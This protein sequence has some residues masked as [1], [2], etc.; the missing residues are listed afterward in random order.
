MKQLFFSLILSF[1]FVMGNAQSSLQE[2]IKA[3]EN[4]NYNLAENIFNS[5]C[6]ADP[7]NSVAH[8]WLGEVSYAKEEY[9]EAEKRYKKGLETNP[10][11]AECHIGLGKLDLD[12]GKVPEAE[13][14][15]ESA[16]RINKKS[17]SIKGLIGDAYLYTKKPNANKAIEYL[18]LASDG[19]PKVGKYW[20]HLGD[21]YNLAGNNGEAMTNYER[22]VEKDPTNTE[23]YIRMA[24]IWRAAKQINDAIPH[25]EKAMQLAP[26]DARPIKDLY[27]LYIYAGKY[28]KVVPLLEKYIALSGTDVEARVRLVKFLAFQAKDYERAITE[29][30]KLLLTSPDQYTLYRWLAWSYVGQAKMMEAQKTAGDS[31]DEAKLKVYWKNAYDHSVK[32]FDDI[33]KKQE[34]KSYPEDYDH[35]ALSA[36]KTGSLEKAAHIYRKYI[37]LE[38]ARANEIYGTLARTY[39]DSAQHE[40]AIK[41]YKLKAIEK[42]L[43]TSEEYY[44]ALAH[45]HLKQ[46][47]ESDSAFARILV[48][49]PNYVQGHLYRAKI[50]NRIDSTNTLFLALPHYEKVIEF[51]T[52][53]EATQEKNKRQLLEAYQW[54]GVY[55]V[56]Q[57][58]NVKGK[59][60]FLKMLALDPGNAKAQEYIEILER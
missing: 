57:G 26:D 28:D 31:I 33:A 43:T 5:L 36:L 32:L 18:T 34:R 14:H 45:Y 11:C 9:T 13:S 30:E 55:Y 27:E 3:L 41:Y 10:Q 7:K 19:D 51:A 58:D 52:V 46:N 59:E 1:L 40:Q 20:A 24:R 17:A 16:I 50:A 22:A 35:W 8:Y 54:M 12:K 47:L 15:F 44:R 23:A 53:D 37:E 6:K 56:Q 48:L 2:G 21:A 39:Y 38:P 25:L 49:T 60:F 42:P 4:E 29:G